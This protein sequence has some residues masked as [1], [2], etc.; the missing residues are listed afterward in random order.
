MQYP[1]QR[2][3]IY[4]NVRIYSI[5]RILILV[6]KILF[7]GRFW[8]DGFII[9]DGPKKEILDSLLSSYLHIISY[10]ILT[11][12]F[13]YFH[14]NSAQ[15]VPQRRM[16]QAVE[17]HKRSINPQNN[18]TGL[19]RTVIKERLFWEGNKSDHWRNL[20]KQKETLTG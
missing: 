15:N 14:K 20:R 18:F 1:R 17:K 6:F 4:E 3:W 13:Q 7:H 19:Q 12:D 10:F 11:N 16:Y 9:F 5:Q 8:D 2:L